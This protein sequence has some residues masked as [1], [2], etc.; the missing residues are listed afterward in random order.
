MSWGKLKVTILVLGLIAVEGRS[1]SLV[2]VE[3]WGVLLF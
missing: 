3:G 1:Y 2:Q